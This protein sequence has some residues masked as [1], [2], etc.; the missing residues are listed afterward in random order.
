M[1]KLMNCA[2]D[3]KDLHESDGL[4]AWE[5]GSH[6]RD[7]LFGRGHRQYSSDDEDDIVE[8]GDGD[9]A[10]VS[11]VDQRRDTRSPVS[12][13]H[14]SSGN[15]HGESVGSFEEV[16]GTLDVNGS[17]SK[18]LLPS[19]HQ[20]HTEDSSARQRIG[21]KT[22]SG[23]TSYLQLE[24][25]GATSGLTSLKSLSG[26]GSPK[27]SMS[28]YELETAN[29]TTSNIPFDERSDTFKPV[30]LYASSAFGD[31][32]MSPRKLYKRS[33]EI[34]R[35]A[36]VSPGKSFKVEEDWSVCTDEREL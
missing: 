31:D 7:S 2:A 30:D 4:C 3:L 22:T 11:A 23:G 25:N 33:G 28:V 36:K 13:R 9:V 6:G 17:L 15:H 35:N 18:V 14:S 1:G 5:D 10:V 32:E 12:R 20:Y 19:E 26:G 24:V 27:Q 16:M 29:P 21:N 34:H 8:H